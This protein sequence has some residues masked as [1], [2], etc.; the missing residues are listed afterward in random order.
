VKKALLTSTSILKVL[1]KA[2]CNPISSTGIISAYMTKTSP[3]G[4][5]SAGISKQPKIASA[6][7]VTVRR[8][9]YPARDHEHFFMECSHFNGD[10]LSLKMRGFPWEDTRVI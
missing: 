2:G 8:I 4:P 5:N 1:M 9:S 10:F 6:P 3:N 7:N